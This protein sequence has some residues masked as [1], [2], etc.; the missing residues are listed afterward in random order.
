MPSMTAN[1]TSVFYMSPFQHC[2]ASKR[3]AF[4]LVCWQGG[5]AV[6]SGTS[7]RT[8]EGNRSNVIAM[9]ALTFCKFVSLSAT[10]IGAVL[11]S[12]KQFPYF[13]SCNMRS[14]K[15]ATSCFTA[16]SST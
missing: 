6:V 11:A 15:I 3:L 2:S 9:L 4:D 12:P 13:D 16:Q 10:P 7:D 5:M 1:K 14:C 8:G